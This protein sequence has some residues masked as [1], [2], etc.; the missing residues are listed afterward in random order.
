M[1]FFRPNMKPQLYYIPADAHK[2][3]LTMGI[4]Y[5]VSLSKEKLDIISRTPPTGKTVRDLF[6]MTVGTVNSELPDFYA[7]VYLVLLRTV[8]M[9]I[10]D[11]SKYSINA[12]VDRG[13][14]RGLK[15]IS[16]VDI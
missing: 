11:F 2:R 15:N 6:Y 16:I 1:V 7:I 13:G 14:G 3:E 5:F 12:T 10:Y 9:I 8:S 4:Q